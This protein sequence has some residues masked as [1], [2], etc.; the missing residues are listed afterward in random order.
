L[1]VNDILLSGIEEQFAILYFVGW[2]IIL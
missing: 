1:Q 2:I